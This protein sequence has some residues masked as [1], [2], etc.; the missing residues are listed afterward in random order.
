[1][2]I[3]RKHGATGTD[4]NSYGIFVDQ[5]NHYLEL[6]DTHS[7]EDVCGMPLGMVSA[8]VELRVGLERA[9]WQM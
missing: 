6:I 2:L 7:R 9:L 5:I 1:M 3:N 8:R 4:A